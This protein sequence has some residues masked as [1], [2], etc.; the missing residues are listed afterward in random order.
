MGEL[1]NSYDPAQAQAQAHGQGQGQEQR[2]EQGQGQG[3]NRFEKG[4]SDD[5]KDDGVPR[6]TYSHPASS[7][8]SGP[9]KPFAQT[10]STEPDADDA[11][12]GG[13][14]A[15]LDRDMMHIVR[16]QED[17]GFMD[18][19]YDH[20]QAHAMD[21]DHVKGLPG[22][23]ADEDDG[24]WLSNEYKGVGEE[25]YHSHSDDSNSDHDNDNDNDNGNEQE[26][27]ETRGSL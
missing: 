23:R 15:S 3:L 24:D 13:S 18:V 22:L 19:D 20:A 2:Q 7:L 1:E 5:D 9:Y 10:I 27:S 4:D 21:D 8:P 25:E 6:E 16:A 12:D 14:D 17:A 11:S 26:K